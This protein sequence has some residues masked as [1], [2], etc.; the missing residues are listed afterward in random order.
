MRLLV[1]LL[2]LLLPSLA[3]AAPLDEVRLPD[4]RH[5]LIAVPQGVA[6]PPLVLALHGGGGNPRQFAGDSGLAETALARGFAVA[7]PAGT[8]KR[9]ARL[10]VWNAGYCCGYAPGAGI[11]DA[12]FL[13][14]V[15][16]D[17]AGRF[18][19]DRT[20]V[21][22]TGMSNGGIMAETYAALR[23]GTVRAAA[24]VAGPMDVA[25]T[26]VKGAV[27]LLHIHGT[28]DDHVPYAGGVGEKSF[29][30]TDFAA[31][32]EVTAAF[33]RAA[34]RPLRAVEDVIDPARDGM[35]V[36]RTRWL[37]PDGRPQVELMTVVGGGHHWPGGRRSARKGA[38][39]DIDAADEVL[40]FFAEHL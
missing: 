15:I 10:L 5:Y 17:A 8:S 40:R 13:D 16:A 1:L 39:R 35:W 25:A 2:G 22:V 21:F 34:A 14:R 7:F 31:V 33:R 18:G 4:G 24:S 32:D 36:E 12:G 37:A 23:P 3:H 30:R 19:I 28:E 29:V 26:A 38:T 27:P 6:H 9:G 20:R 11:D